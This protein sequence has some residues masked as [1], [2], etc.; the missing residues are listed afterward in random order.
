[1]ESISLFAFYYKFTP[2]MFDLKKKKDKSTVLGVNIK[3]LHKW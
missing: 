1:M 2:P 3:R